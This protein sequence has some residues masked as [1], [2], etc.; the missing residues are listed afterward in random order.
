MLFL[1]KEERDSLCP[2][3]H[4][5]ISENEKTKKVC[6]DL[7]KE[8]QCMEFIGGHIEEHCVLEYAR[9]SD[10]FKPLHKFYNKP[11]IN[12]KLHKYQPYIFDTDSFEYDR[13][14]NNTTSWFDNKINGCGLLYSSDSEEDED[15]KEI[16]AII[17][18]KEK[19]IIDKCVCDIKE[20]IKDPKKFF[21]ENILNKEAR[22]KIIGEYLYRVSN[23]LFKKY[24]KLKTMY[25]GL[26]K[27]LFVIEN[28]DVIKT[29]YNIKE[30]LDN[31]DTFK[32]SICLEHKT[33]STT[34]DYC[35]MRNTCS[36]C[37]QEIINKHKK[38]PTCRTRFS[39]DIIYLA[40]SMKIQR[41]LIEINCDDYPD[42]FQNRCACC[43]GCPLCESLSV[44]GA[45]GGVAG[46]KCEVHDLDVI[47]FYKDGKSPDGDDNFDDIKFVQECGMY[48]LS[49]PM[50]ISGGDNIE[51]CGHS[52]N[53][54]C[55]PPY[56]GHTL[57]NHYHDVISGIT[58]VF[59]M[60]IDCDNLDGYASFAEWG[61]ASCSQ[62]PLYI[63]PKKGR[64]IPEDLWWFAIDSVR[65][66]Q[67]LTDLK[68]QYHTLILNSINPSI[69]S[70]D[71][72]IT[73]LDKACKGKEY[74]CEYQENKV[75]KRDYKWKNTD[76]NKKKEALKWVDE[77][78]NKPS[79]MLL[80]KDLSE[81]KQQAALFM[82]LTEEDFN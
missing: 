40:G 16:C 19:K 44:D 21:Y 22:E 50:R 76:Y 17:K 33:Y 29:Y 65:S 14:S 63:I 64:W 5:Y 73:M 23:Y 60:T 2:Y 30:Y 61:M 1:T 79:M 38:C 20:K 43:D 37:I 13:Y 4:Q 48:T 69:R 47:D 15:I 68:K 36:D 67:K 58:D 24:V 75:I 7:S 46:C 66:I 72:Y 42:I 28:N 34:I 9:T 27:Q 62:K 54:P 6:G 35:C 32:C 52:C 18:K 41:P 81:E 49:G 3:F 8:V 25:P 78:W 53:I 10:I 45:Y 26:N 77:I 12:I 51:N 55:I 59:I 80:W 74:S 57:L 71:M 82:G 39:K 31:P 70:I 56:F 11:E